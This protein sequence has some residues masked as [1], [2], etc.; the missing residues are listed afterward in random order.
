MWTSNGGIEFLKGIFESL[1]FLWPLSFSGSFESG[2]ISRNRV[3][4]V[5]EIFLKFHVAMD[6]VGFSSGPFIDNFLFVRNININSSVLLGDMEV[7]SLELISIS[8]LLVDDFSFGNVCLDVSFPFFSL[9][10]SVVVVGNEIANDGFTKFSFFVINVSDGSF[11]FSFGNKRVLLIKVFS[12]FLPRVLDSLEFL[13]PDFLCLSFSHIVDSPFLFLGFRD[14]SPP[15]SLGSILSS[16]WFGPFVN[17]F[18]FVG[19]VEFTVTSWFTSVEMSVFDLVFNGLG[20]S[21]VDLKLLF[22]VFVVG[23]VN[24]SIWSLIHLLFPSDGLSD[25]FF[26]IDNR[27]KVLVGIFSNFH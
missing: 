7:F 16:D 20:V 1:E 13:W 19:P 12:E 26:S 25:S 22:N 14:F 10:N 27:I 15:F 11:D 2:F 18:L 6:A 17:N 24:N 9:V 8:E 23:L 4:V 5:N 3:L 21:F